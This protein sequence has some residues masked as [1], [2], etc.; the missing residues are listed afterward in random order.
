MKPATPVM[1]Q[2]FL[3][4]R[5]YFWIWVYLDIFFFFW[6]PVKQ[7]QKR[8]HRAGRIYRILQDFFWAIGH[9]RWAM[10]YRQWA[11]G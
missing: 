3:F 9:R 6:T 1:S 5:R 7:K 11:I 10:G 2:I 8:F 4:D